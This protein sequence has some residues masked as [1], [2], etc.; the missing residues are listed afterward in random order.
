M[1]TLTSNETTLSRSRAARREAEALLRR[2]EAE[3]EASE[4]RFA[5]D[6]RS[7][8]LRQV[9]GRNSLDGAIESVRLMLDTLDRNIREAE[10]IRA[11]PRAHTQGRGLVMLECV[12][13]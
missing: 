6:Q 4:R 7:D 11:R 2:L 12:G 9:T 10:R 8:L 13:D 1:T 5:E 3:R